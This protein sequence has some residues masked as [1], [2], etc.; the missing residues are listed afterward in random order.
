MIS[1]GGGGGYVLVV[2][3][4][5]G[6]YVLVVKFIGE[7]LSRGDYVRIPNGST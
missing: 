1:Y 3:F 6:D 7:V 2:K 4:T 5:G